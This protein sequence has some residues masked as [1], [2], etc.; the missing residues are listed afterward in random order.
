[1]HDLEPLAVIDFPKAM[2]FWKMVLGQI[3]YAPQEGFP[4]IQTFG[5]ESYCPNFSIV[6]G[7][8]ERFDRHV[9]YLQVDDSE[10]VEAVYGKAIAA[11]GKRILVDDKEVGK[12][13][14]VDGDRFMAKFLD[15][16]GNTVEVYVADL[17]ASD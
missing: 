7:N 10:E 8:G 1:M 17:Y 2:E 11:G 12:P 15:L 5:K 14:F 6:Q 13:G 16:D 3:G 4:N 9:I